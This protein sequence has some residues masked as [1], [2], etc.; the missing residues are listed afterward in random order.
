MNWFWFMRA[1]QNFAKMK[2]SPLSCRFK[3]RLV[4]AK[5][6]SMGEYC[7]TLKYN[8][9]NKLLL[10]LNPFK[11]NFTDQKIL[12]EVE[13]IS[14]KQ[15]DFIRLWSTS[16]K[17]METIAAEIGENRDSLLKW[18]HQFKKEIIILK[19]DAFD[20]ILENN[21]L[22]SVSRFTY[23]CELYNKLKKELDNRDFTSLP[24]D[25]LYYILDDV[26]DLIKTIKNEPLTRLNK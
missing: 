6:Q 19:A 7:V 5:V 3:K 14:A 24:T 1:L 4:K 2:S 23:L 26:Y 21:N 18:E 15:N 13:M 11:D 8:P 9:D 16:G 25:K 20:K 22:S 10:P 12:V 17:S